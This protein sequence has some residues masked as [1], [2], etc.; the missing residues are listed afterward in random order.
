MPTTEYLPYSGTHACADIDTTIDEVRAARGNESSLNARITSDVTTLNTAIATKANSSDMTTALAAKADK[1][2]VNAALATKADADDVT[3]ALATKANT[4]D[5]TTALAGKQDTLTTAQL[6]AV[7]SGI[8]STKVAAIASNTTA[9][10][11]KQ[12]ALT[13][14]Q[15]AALDETT[16]TAFEVSVLNDT[17]GSADIQVSELEQGYYSSVDGSKQDSSSYVRSKNIYPIEA[18]VF[19]R[20]TTSNQVQACLYD[21]DMEFI[22]RIYINPRTTTAKRTIIPDNAKYAGLFSGSS[23]SAIGIE[24][25]DSSNFT[26]AVHPYVADNVDFAFGYWINGAGNIAASENFML[27][28]LYNVKAGERYYVSNDASNNGIC[29]DKSGNVLSVEYTS[30]PPYGKIFTVPEGTVV[31]Y[32]NLYTATKKGVNNEYAEYVA[33]VTQKEKVLCIG[34]SVTWLDGRGTYGGS[35]HLMGYQRI[36]RMAGFEVQSAGYSGYP[37]SEGIHDQGDV[38][39]SIYNEIVGKEYD[40]SGYDIIL[41]VGGLND[42]SLGSTIGTRC[43]DYTSDTFDTDT[44]NGA[45]CG[46][47]QYIRTT[48]ITAKIILCTTLKSEDSSR[49]WTRSKPVNDEI[50]YNAEFW[51]CNLLDL[52][53]KINIQPK[54]GQFSTFFYDLTHPNWNGMGRMGE[55]I[56]N[57][58]ESVK[59]PKL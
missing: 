39:Y 58:V 46:I 27:L 37:Y 53:E 36:M 51:S 47:I 45:L 18:G 23:A 52:F 16:Q 49:V 22:S 13:E 7:N 24:K 8:D 25:T 14:E 1:T 4:S 2:T 38:K 21:K 12:D 32:F 10:E 26:C 40:L 35:T 59:E 30:V 31:I 48:N 50:H 54:C 34:D 55:L 11:G 57:A 20:S 42:I 9:I 56:L 3:T 29:I 6:N 15:L 17:V 5:M 28:S 44:F 43:T 33:K 19:Y 41:L